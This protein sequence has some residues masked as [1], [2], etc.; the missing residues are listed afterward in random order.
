MAFETAVVLVL[1]LGLYIME[2]LERQGSERPRGEVG[3]ARS[4]EGLTRR[5]FVGALA[6]QQAK[7]VLGFLG[8]RV[9][10]EGRGCLQL[11]LDR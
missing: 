10:G 5:R 3:A 7:R 1:G 6:G 11:R 4:Q 9:G 8:L 2:E